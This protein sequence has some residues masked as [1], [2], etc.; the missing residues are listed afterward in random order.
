MFEFYSLVNK[1][2][3]QRI[4]AN[5]NP[6]IGNDNFPGTADK[7]VNTITEAI[8]RVNTDAGDII[9]AVSSSI[10]DPPENQYIFSENIVLNKNNTAIIGRWTNEVTSGIGIN[11]YHP[12]VITGC[13]LL[14]GA[15]GGNGM[16][17]GFRISNGSYNFIADCFWVDFETEDQVGFNLFNQG[18]SLAD[19]YGGNGFIFCR[20]AGN[21]VTGSI[22]FKLQDE[23]RDSNFLLDCAI[24]KNEVGVQIINSALQGEHAIV[25]CRFN[26]NDIPLIQNDGLHSW[27]LHGNYYSDLPKGYDTVGK[28]TTWPNNSA[29]WTFA[30]PDEL[31]I[32]NIGAIL[33]N[34][35]LPVTNM[36]IIRNQLLKNINMG[37]FGKV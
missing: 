27:Y 10:S 8:N 31:P 24:G 5:A 6:F 30:H 12:N 13:L 9:I 18:G 11:I 2:R 29:S 23:G 4:Y 3:G 22:G 33:A 34:K 35:M 28:E 14:G 7:P 15:I 36:A 37:G 26:G 17:E 16:Q 20:A 1:Y 19:L 25:N 21:N 32:R